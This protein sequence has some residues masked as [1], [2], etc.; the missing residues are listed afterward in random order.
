MTTTI[1][2]P[3]PTSHPTP[4][5]DNSCDLYNDDNPDLETISDDPDYAQALETWN[6]IC[7]TTA[8]AMAGELTPRPTA[9]RAT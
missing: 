4:P 1:L 2:E 6:E 8:L 5:Q 9:W 3:S 7:Q